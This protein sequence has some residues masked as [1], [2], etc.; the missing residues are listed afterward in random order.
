M[1]K[2]ILDQSSGY[3]KIK[4]KNLK[5]SILG[6]LI[7]NEIPLTG[8]QRKIKYSNFSIFQGLHGA[9]SEKKGWQILNKSKVH[10]NVKHWN[11]NFKRAQKNF[12]FADDLKWS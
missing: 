1:N 3:K 8:T 9:S 6:T 12:E 5:W 2:K 10:E 7:L 4:L 11:M